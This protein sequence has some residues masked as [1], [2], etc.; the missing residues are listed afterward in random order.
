MLAKK[1]LLPISVAI[2][3]QAIMA[4]L[5]KMTILVVIAW[6]NM[7]TDVVKSDFFVN[8]RINVDHQ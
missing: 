4:K 1:S 3:S 2:I 6:L 7:A 8:R 5:A